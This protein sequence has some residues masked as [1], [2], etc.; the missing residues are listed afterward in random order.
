M[1]HASDGL[2]SSAGRRRLA[3]LVAGV[4]ALLVAAIVVLNRLGGFNGF[5]LSPDAGAWAYLAMA[6]IVLT[7]WL[8]VVLTT[9]ETAYFWPVWPILGGA[10]GLL[11][12]MLPVRTYCR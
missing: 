6:A 7:V 11:G 10:I 4:L 8:A 3:L 5:S 2:V 1:A 12:N 9:G